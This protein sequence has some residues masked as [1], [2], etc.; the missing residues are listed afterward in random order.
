MGINV[1][2]VNESAIVPFP[3]LDINECLASNPCHKEATCLNTFGSSTCTCNTGFVGDGKN[4][5]GTATHLCT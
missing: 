4:C 1:N 3:F 5:Q 2:L